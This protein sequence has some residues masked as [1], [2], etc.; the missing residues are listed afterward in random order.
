MKWNRDLL[1]THASSFMFHIMQ[2]LHSFYF[3]LGLYVVDL[4]SHC[5][6]LTKWWLKLI[7]IILFLYLVWT[8][9]IYLFKSFIK[10]TNKCNFFYMLFFPFL[11]SC[12]IHSCAGGL[13]GFFLHRLPLHLFCCFSFSTWFHMNLP[14]YLITQP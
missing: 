13:S 7:V 2:E 8:L 1:I 3:L 12:L 5:A 6:F 10:Y 14:R 9:F 4:F 11:F